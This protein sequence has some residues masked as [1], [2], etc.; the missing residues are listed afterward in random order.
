M[1][2]EFTVSAEGLVDVVLAGDLPLMSHA[3]K[4]CI[5]TRPP[6][7]ASQDGP[8]T[9]WIDRAIADL[10]VRIEDEEIAPFA[11]GNVTYLHLRHGVVEARPSLSA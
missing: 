11:A 5:G 10:K 7:D 2:Y 6:R 4:D 3:L 8:S 9:F 1:E